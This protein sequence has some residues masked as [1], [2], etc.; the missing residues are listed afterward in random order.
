MT[1]DDMS[2]CMKFASTDPKQSGHLSGYTLSTC[3]HEINVCNLMLFIRSCS[4]DEESKVMSRMKNDMRGTLRGAIASC[5]VACCIRLCMLML[6]MM[7]P[8]ESV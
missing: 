7:M 8:H 4:P 6:Q 1:E 2:N 5:I 3:V